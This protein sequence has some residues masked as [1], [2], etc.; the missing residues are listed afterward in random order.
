MVRHSIV[1]DAV[2]PSGW[3]QL[4]QQAAVAA[5]ASRKVRTSSVVWRR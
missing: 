1:T 2:A 4:P 3:K 5:A